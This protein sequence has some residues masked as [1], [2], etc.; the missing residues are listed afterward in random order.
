MSW[1]SGR[2]GLSHPWIS[3]DSRI[4]SQPTPVREFV[5]PYGAKTREFVDAVLLPASSSTAHRI[6]PR[7]PKIV[8]ATQDHLPAFL[9][10]QLL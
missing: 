9:V 1:F 7:R 4:S 2:A 10:R 8:L 5:A 6:E 3:F